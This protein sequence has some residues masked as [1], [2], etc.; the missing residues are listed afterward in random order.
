MNKTKKI[1]LIKIEKLNEK[2]GHYIKSLPPKYTITHHHP[3]PPHL[4]LRLLLRL[5]LLFF[6]LCYG[7]L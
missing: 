4:H 7:K 3:P 5:G 2:I 6:G 1:K